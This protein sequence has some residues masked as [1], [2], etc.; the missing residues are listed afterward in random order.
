MMSIT[1]TLTALLLVVPSLMSGQAESSP[2]CDPKYSAMSATHSRCLPPKDEA[3]LEPLSQET[4]N[5]IVRLHNNY[6]SKID[7]PAS[8]M[9][10]LYW[11][12][13]L[14]KTVES[15]MMQ[16]EGNH[17]A[18]GD[19]M[20][21]DWPNVKIGQ[22]IGMNHKGWQNMLNKFWIEQGIKRLNYTYEGG[23]VTGLGHF[24]QMA[25]ARSNRIGCAMVKC[26]KRD[27]GTYTYRACN[28]APCL[29]AGDLAYTK[30]ESAS[31]C[32]DHQTANGTLCD[33]KD[34]LCYHEG[35]LDVGTCTC[36]CKGIWTGDNCEKI[37]CLQGES[38]SCKSKDCNE[39][40]TKM[41]CPHTCGECTN[42]QGVVC[43]NG[44][45]NYETCTCECFEGYN[46]E[47][48]DVQVCTEPDNPLCTRIKAL[49]QCDED[50]K[51]TASGKTAYCPMLCGKCKTNCPP[52][53]N[54]GDLTDLNTCACKC[55]GTFRGERCESCEAARD[56]F[57]CG[58]LKAL[59]GSCDNT[60]SPFYV[61]LQTDCP[62]LCGVC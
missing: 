12:D 56:Q 42:C 61:V 2:T 43:N 7:P 18:M 15:L 6:R 50:G 13:T 57:V 26:K 22:N 23:Y 14:A 16:C 10:K 40:Q 52:C 4:K 5:E 21:P 17:D 31:L 44:V 58:S 8:D 41:F 9:L 53:E 30:G 20:E 36:Q 19:R 11:D 27:K 35:V 60:A 51:M 24:Y 54:F 37:D 1:L 59:A 34:K 47:S 49:G 45:L 46:G 28:Y 55:K 3:K 48:C 29:N 25:T 39:P 32:P 62:L 38:S 33:C